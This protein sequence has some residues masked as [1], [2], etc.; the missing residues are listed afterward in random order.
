MR[1]QRCPR[2]ALACVFTILARAS[3][4]SAEASEG[5]VDAPL[6][7]TTAPTDAPLHEGEASI[8]E[9]VVGSALPAPNKDEQHPA[10][11]FD[12]AS[13]EASATRRLLLGAE[14]GVAWRRVD[15]PIRYEPGLWR[16]LAARL[17]PADWLTLRAA[18]N[19]QFHEVELGSSFAAQG[20]PQARPELEL[21]LLEAS[22][23]PV[24]R[25]ARAWE[26]SFGLSA[27]WAHVLE[28]R[29]GSPSLTL[30]ARSGSVQ[31]YGLRL[32]LD[33][34]AVPAWLSLGVSAQGAETLGHRGRLFRTTQAVQAS[35]MLEAVPGL[36][37]FGS[38]LAVGLNASIIL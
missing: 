8:D 22:L 30:H 12:S 25:L 32:G 2:L 34:E 33:W 24:L 3:L 11:Y 23:E 4:A 17:Y 18:G 28:V 27:A 1:S 19:K 36:P 9:D 29:E 21:T 7:E 10:P 13:Q 38:A 37:R 5:M 26:L 16:G 20:S 31:Q 6:D 35:G 15:G 14:A